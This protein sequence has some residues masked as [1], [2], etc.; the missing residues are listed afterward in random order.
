MT[1]KLSALSARHLDL[2]VG[3]P[4]RWLS[5]VLSDVLCDGFCDCESPPHVQWPWRV[6]I[7][8]RPTIAVTGTPS[9]ASGD[10]VCVVNC[11]KS[12][13]ECI[14]LGWKWGVYRQCAPKSK[15][16]LGSHMKF[17]IKG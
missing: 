10:R 1:S 15:G 6:A 5:D 8:S 4:L 14:F 17:S 2:G 7:G 13:I 16:N 12:S 3:V 9:P 11:R